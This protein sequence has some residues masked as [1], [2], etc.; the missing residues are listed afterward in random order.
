MQEDIILKVVGVSAYINITYV[1]ARHFDCNK[2]VNYAKKTAMHF[3]SSIGNFVGVT[4]SPKNKLT[5]FR[6]LT[7]WQS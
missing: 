1:D 5:P 4:F 3:H 6:D 2:G 7:E